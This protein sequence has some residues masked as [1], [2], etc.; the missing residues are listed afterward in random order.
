MTDEQD[1]KEGLQLPE[2]SF[3]AR[4]EFIRTRFITG[5]ESILPT[6]EIAELGEEVA[7][8]EF[9]QVVYAGAE[10]PYIQRQV[11][12]MLGTDIT[13]KPDFI[14]RGESLIFG[15][16]EFSGIDTNLYLLI[17]RFESK[18]GIKEIEIIFYEEQLLEIFEETMDLKRINND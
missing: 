13:D 5:D 2:M 17:R 12:N 6:S 9:D 7:K 10:D 8:V 18:E 1:K 4:L 16:F 11:A 14:L 3:K 15:V